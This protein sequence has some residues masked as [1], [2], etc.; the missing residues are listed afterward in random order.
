METQT[1]TCSRCVAG[2]ECVRHDPARPE[3]HTHTVV[4]GRREAGCPR[5]A[6]LHAGAPPI[7]WSNGRRARHAEE[8]RRWLQ[9]HDCRRSNCGPVCTFGD[10]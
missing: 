3:K 8:D 10:W 7:Q 1:E 2:E 9:Q 4:F 5:C 6:Q